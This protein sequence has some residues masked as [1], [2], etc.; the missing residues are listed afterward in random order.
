MSYIDTYQASGMF[1]GI[2]EFKKYLFNICYVAG[3]GKPQLCMKDMA[4]T[5]TEL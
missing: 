2:Y 3:I 1:P 4:S 5:I